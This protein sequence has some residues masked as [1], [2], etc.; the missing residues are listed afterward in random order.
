MTKSENQLEPGTPGQQKRNADPSRRRFL[1]A[2][3][4]GAVA[5]TV[6]LAGITEMQQVETQAELEDPMEKALQRYG[7]E[8]GNIKRIG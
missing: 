3:A 7:S 4:A 8:M 5:A 6:P 2:A 1:Q